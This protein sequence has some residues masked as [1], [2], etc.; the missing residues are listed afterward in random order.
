M[1][2]SIIVCPSCD[3]DV[4]ANMHKPERPM[5]CNVCGNHVMLY[6]CGGCDTDVVKC[7]QCG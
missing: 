5:W 1:A 7:D 3:G 2:E 4:T 6:K